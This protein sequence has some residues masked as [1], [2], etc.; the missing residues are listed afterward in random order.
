MSRLPRFLPD[1]DRPYPDIVPECSAHLLYGI[2]FW[3]PYINQF[4]SGPKWRL[5][6]PWTFTVQ[7]YGSFTVPANYIFDKASIPPFFHGLGY[8]PDGPCTMPA[9]QHDYLCDILQGGSD[10]LKQA[11]GGQVPKAPPPAVIHSSF[12]QWLLDEGERPS[13]A[14]AM[15]W[16]VRHFGPGGLWRPME[17]LRTIFCLKPTYP[18]D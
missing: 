7:G 9:L 12:Q 3:V 18:T 5:R 6:K 2:L 13:K 4:F 15:G 10:W 1:P 17:I 11:L 16:A 8:T 14:L